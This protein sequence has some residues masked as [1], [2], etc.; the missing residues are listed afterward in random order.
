MSIGI[1]FNQK[2]IASHILKNVI[3]QDRTFHCRIVCKQW[4]KIVDE[5]VLKLFIRQLQERRNEIPESLGLRQIVVIFTDEANPIN[6]IN[7][8]CDFA[9]F[10]AFNESIEIIIG[11]KTG[12]ITSAEQVKDL[13]Q[14][15]NLHILWDAIKDQVN[16]A[17]VSPLYTYEEISNWMRTNTASLN[18]INLLTLKRKELTSLP[19]EIGLLTRLEYLDLGNNKI[20]SLSPEIGNLHHLRVLNLNTNKLTNLPSE[21]GNLTSLQYLFLADNQLQDLP[22]QIVHLQNLEQLSLYSNQIQTLTS[23]IASLS[24]LKKLE[25]GDNPLS[26]VDE[27]ILSS[28][29]EVFFLNP[30]IQNFKKIRNLEALL[31]LKALYLEILKWE[32]KTEISPK[33]QNAFE[34]LFSEDKNLV[35]EMMISKSGKVIDLKEV[36]ANSELF[37][38]AVN[39][40]V[41]SRN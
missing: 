9:Q 2:D 7:I 8:K 24:K 18:S 1:V 19:P 22:A 34:D 23:N 15:T 29:K 30:R 31:K 17:P 32:N 27:T 16:P 36:F 28:D 40:V 39:E 20:K 35:L 12:L 41:L 6:Q 10:R 3:I 11:R 5:D 33:V 37:E 25:L 4:K 26:F 13:A 38:S 14:G 21:I